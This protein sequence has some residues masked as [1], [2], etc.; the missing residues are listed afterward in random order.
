MKFL[1]INGFDSY[2]NVAFNNAAKLADDT[3]CENLY[4][5]HFLVALLDN[6]QIRKDF[7]YKTGIN[8]E[9]LIG[10][11]EDL[12][13]SG[14]Y[15]YKEIPD[16]FNIN[17][18]SEEVR[19]AINKMIQSRYQ[20][21]TV[22]NPM[23][24]YISLMSE[25]NT[26]ITSV[27]ADINPQ[28]DLIELY[29]TDEDS[30]PTL[31]SVAVNLNRLAQQKKI[32]PVDARDDVI[33]QVIEVLG[34]RQKGNPCLI[35]DAG[36]GKTAIVEGLAQRIN[37]G[38]VPNYLKKHKIISV[39]ISSIVGGTKFRGD[40]EDKLN[41]I[42]Y[43]AVDQGNVILFFDEIHMLMGAGKNNEGGTT[44]VNILK[45]ALARGDIR[46][47]GA[48]T[49]KEWKRFIEVDSAF[50]RRLQDIVVNEPTVPQAIR[51]LK[52]VVPLY[53][54]YHNAIID[55]KVIEYAVKL[56]DRYITNRRLP[57]KAITVIDE[58]GAR[59]K[60]KLGDDSI[61]SMD[62]ND[63]RKTVSRITGIDVNE[64]D[65]DSTNK[66]LN[67]GDNLRKR[68]IG[69]DNAVD[70]VTKAI[71][72]SRAGIKNP[73]KPIGTF[74]F[75]GPT[76]VGKTEL[77][78]ALATEFSGSIK[79]LIRFD[80]SEFMEKHSVSKLI[81][82]PPGYVGFGD[83]G[84][85]T[86]AVKRN[87]YSVVLFDEIEKAHP[88]IFNIFLQIMDDGFLNDSQGVRVDFKNTIIIMTSN[89]GYGIENRS[90]SIGF[91]S[92]S[93]D[94]LPKQSEDKA[95][96][97]L[98]NTF[99]PEFLNRLD[100]VV[101]FNSLGKEE[102]KE[103]VELMLEEI[104]ERLV[105]KSIKIKWTDGAVNKLIKD[106]FDDKYGARNLRRKIQNTIEDKVADMII[107]S[108]IRSG[109][110]VLI[111]GNDSMGINF[112]VENVVTI[113]KQEYTC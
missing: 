7:E 71:K 93:E 74:L 38:K 4:A 20:T 53:T 22:V 58:T 8:K 37:E 35:G 78:K 64:L 57:D 43:E 69:Q 47:I 51:M 62:I 42:L 108:S 61:F 59:I 63:I 106:G 46:I 21:G 23:D 87:P 25:E 54:E 3:E 97:A 18:I 99:R 81:G 95:I 112:K 82:S 65:N 70:A 84:Q 92:N 30:M 10:K 49:T 66:L 15:G 50:E 28:L 34:R 90:I 103:I 27:I 102:C 107:E 41:N 13:N 79:N 86:E 33:N 5:V 91:N 9:E 45:P 17:N 67:L 36:V 85:L 44:A 14:E 110:I 56:S 31:M 94:K 96:K 88:D 101:V 72:R 105:D 55:D 111:D 60:A 26:T 98:E 32:D 40:F 109:D 1:G 80:M 113:V 104:N 2:T 100:K 11:I 6:D 29:R 89:A 68:V 24:A 52:K 73:N 39:D 77:S 76:G 83:G 16:E 75:V 48:T 19:H 12:T